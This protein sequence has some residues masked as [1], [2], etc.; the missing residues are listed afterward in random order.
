MVFLKDGTPSKLPFASLG[1][2]TI[3]PEQLNAFHTQNDWKIHDE[4]NVINAFL[5]KTRP[6]G[7]DKTQVRRGR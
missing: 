3:I 6:R 1:R 7:K 2:C 5:I 4:Q